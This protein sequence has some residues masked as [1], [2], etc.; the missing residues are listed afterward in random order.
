M[1]IPA[2]EFDSLDDDRPEIDLSP[3]TTQGTI[4]RF[5]LGN[6]DRA[7]RQREIIAA[8]DVP[9]GSV[10]PTLSRL[11]DHDLVDHRG[12]YWRVD[13][14]AHAVASGA[15]LGTE[16]ADEV[17][18]G[19][20]DDEVRAWMETAVDPVDDSSSEVEDDRGS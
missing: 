1:P 4:Y 20:S 10:G 12:Q 6:A 5:L 11:E 8:L 7:F 2:D 3:D 17:D 18:G 9:A 19:F 14:A 16:S 13:D 15:V